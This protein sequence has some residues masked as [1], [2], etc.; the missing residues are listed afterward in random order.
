LGAAFAQ[1]QGL[2]PALKNYQQK[3][4]SLPDK[5][6][7]KGLSPAEQEKVEQQAT[8]L[9]EKTAD[10][11]KTLAMGSGSTL[12]CLQDCSTKFDSCN[13]SATDWF[14]RYLCNIDATKC[15]IACVGK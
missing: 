7:A 2:S 13:K 5:G 4:E 15:T 1:A 6:S 12:S 9:R 14:Q 3:L 11:A 10:E 8:Q